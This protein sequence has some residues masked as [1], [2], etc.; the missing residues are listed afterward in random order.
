LTLSPA[1]GSVWVSSS[2]S[3][4][5]FFLDPESLTMRPE[6]A[7]Y[8]SGTPMFGAITPDGKTLYMPYR[9]QDVV[10][11]LDTTT[12]PPG[13]KTDI[14]LGP[15]GCVS[16]HQVTLTPD[17]KHLLAVCEGDH[18]GPGT[19]HVVDLEAGTVVKTVPVG[20]FPDSV[21]ILRRTAP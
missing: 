19:L 8:H 6:R 5:V 11:V 9:V 14:A 20:V 10:A 15:S 13:L 7:V 1:D 18:H 2:N 3:S 12:T 16:V 17:G 21:N 4:T